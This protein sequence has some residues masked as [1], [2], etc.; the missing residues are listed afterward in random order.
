MPEIRAT[1]TTLAALGIGT[2]ASALVELLPRQR[3]T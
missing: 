2:A 3:P 1:V